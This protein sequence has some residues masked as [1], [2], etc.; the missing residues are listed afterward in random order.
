MGLRGQPT[1]HVQTTTASNAKWFSVERPKTKTN[2]HE[3]RKFPELLKATNSIQK[4]K[5]TRISALGL[6]SQ[7]PSPS[8]LD[9]N[10]VN[11]AGLSQNSICFDLGNHSAMK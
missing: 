3:V 4:P 6:A 8:I 1:A 7:A 2:H 11:D 9:R 5:Q 10:P